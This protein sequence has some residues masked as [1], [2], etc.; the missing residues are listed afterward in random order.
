ME[1]PYYPDIPLLGAY[2]SPNTKA[3]FGKN[4]FTYMFIAA[5]IA[6]A[7]REK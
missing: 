6:V 1:F 7:K 4:I 5:L 2:L 3:L